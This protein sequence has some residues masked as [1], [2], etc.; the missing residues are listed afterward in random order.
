MLGSNNDKAS[1]RRSGS[2]RR[3]NRSKKGS[4][5]YIPGAPPD[6]E[7][8][9]P[10]RDRASHTDFRRSSPVSSSC[11][12]CRNSRSCPGPRLSSSPRNRTMPPGHSWRRISRLFLR[13]NQRCPCLSS[14]TWLFCR[15]SRRNFGACRR[16]L[17]S[18]PLSS[19]RQT[20]SCRSSNRPFWYRRERISAPASKLAS[21]F[22]DSAQDE[23]IIQRKR[24]MSLSFIKFDLHTS[25]FRFDESAQGIPHAAP[26][27]ASN[28]AACLCRR[29]RRKSD[30]KDGAERTVRQQTTAAQAALTERFA[31]PPEWG[32]RTSR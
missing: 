8:S 3:P 15:L 30:T 10:L 22:V 12:P 18:D 32:A 13:S 16:A 29:R 31:A 23:R 27:R 5:K 20:P 4:P 19:D 14:T 6:Q 11:R 21:Q 2:I 1:T 26:A 9:C 7:V 17:H 25:M 24:A 28:V